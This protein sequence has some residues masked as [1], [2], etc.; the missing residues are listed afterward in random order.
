M[1]AGGA[2]AGYI[3]GN[4]ASNLI[5][6]LVSA[7]VADHFGLASNFYFFAVLNLAGA[8]LVYFTVQRAP[9]AHCLG[10]TVD[11][12][13]ASWALHLRNPRLVAAFGIGF[14]IL[15]AFIGTFTYVNFVLVRPPFMTGPMELG[16][17]YFVFSAFTTP[18]AGPVIG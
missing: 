10:R 11:T 16:F 17:V 14:C 1:D 2:F 8:V 9:P 18:L 13:F 15:F 3:T 5:G 4:V 6:R 12:Q 7:G